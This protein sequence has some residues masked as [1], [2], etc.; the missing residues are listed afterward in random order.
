M[1]MYENNPLYEKLASY[2]DC[3][4]PK[5]REI[6]W[7][8]MTAIGL[9]AVDLLTVSDFLLDLAIKNIEGEISMDGVTKALN[10]H[11]AEKKKDK[12]RK[13][14]CTYTRIYRDRNGQYEFPFKYEN[15]D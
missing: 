4:D 5:K 15:E 13:E 12:I 3:T 8:W 10:K 1:K 6:A 2:K 14:Y 9:Q 7:S 11:Y